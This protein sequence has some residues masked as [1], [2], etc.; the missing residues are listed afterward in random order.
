MK[1]KSVKPG[2]NISKIEVTNISQHGFWLYHGGKEYFLPFE[3]YPWFMN[4][5]VNE[6]TNVTL[7]NQHHLYWEKLD[8]DLSLDILSHP[9]RFPL[10]FVN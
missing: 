7:I 2:K 4:A 5:N 6:I 9:G 3:E 10:K 1:A 8:V